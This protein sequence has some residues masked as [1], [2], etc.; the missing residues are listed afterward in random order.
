MVQLEMKKRGSERERERVVVRVLEGVS[1]NICALS[2][3]ALLSAR[4]RVHWL[5]CWS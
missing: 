4:S 5:Q 2:S 1:T 3:V